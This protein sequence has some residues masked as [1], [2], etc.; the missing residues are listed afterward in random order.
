[1]P[2]HTPWLGLRAQI[3]LAL[4]LVFIALFWLLGFATVRITQRTAAAENARAEQLLERALSSEWSRASQSDVTQLDGMCAALRSRFESVRARLTRAD[5]TVYF[6]GVA[7]LPT[8]DARS[9]RLRTARGTELAS[10][11]RLAVQLPDASEQST[12]TVARLLL[13]YMALTGSCVVL[14]S[15][16]LLTHLIV[17]PLERLTRSTEQFALGVLQQPVAEQGAA[18]TV[19]LSRTFNRMAALL[20]A[21]R[22]ALTD[23]LAELERTT[24]ELQSTQRQLIHGEKLASVGR[25]AAGIAHEIGN[26]LTAISGLIELLQSGDLSEREQREFLVR[27]AAETERISGIIRNLLDFAR[28]DGSPGELTESSDLRAAIDDAVNLMRPQKSSRAVQIS[29]VIAPSLGEHVA[30]VGARARLTQVL[31][32]LLLNAL[33]ALSGPLENGAR[34]RAGR[35]EIAAEPD[36]DGQHV[37]LFVRD[38]GPGIAPEIAHSLFEPFSTTKPPGKGTGLGLAVTHAIVESL[39]GSIQAWNQSH[40]G[41]CFELRL[42]CAGEPSRTRTAAMP[43]A[44]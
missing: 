38:D 40:G 28:Q 6:C 4:S 14:F 8:R 9:L 12:R 22:T 44:V 31:L 27:I 7:E 13:F 32:N 20:R 43:R 35:I 2:V 17:R 18:E 37:R 42:P 33:D 15:Y 16:V 30:V 29:V 39:G 19:R 25:L 41:A 26:P 3:A 1:M 5:G 34:S 36:A 24:S 23:R 11:G 21:E 10:G